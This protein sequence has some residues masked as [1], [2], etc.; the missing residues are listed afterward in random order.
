MESISYKLAVLLTLAVPDLGSAQ[1]T[2]QVIRAGDW[3]V[4]QSSGIELILDGQHL[5]LGP[6]CIAE[7]G[8]TGGSVRFIVPAPSQGPEVRGFTVGAIL[9]DSWM[10]A[11]H[12]GELTLGKE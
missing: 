6:S 12:S 2:G 3:A 8:V 10:H 4:Y 11:E 9:A 1:A 5:A 7:I